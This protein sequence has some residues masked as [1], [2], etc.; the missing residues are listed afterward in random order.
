MVPWVEPVFIEVVD[1]RRQVKIFV[2]IIIIYTE[3]LLPYNRAYFFQFAEG[4]IYNRLDM[5]CKAID[6]QYVLQGDHIVITGSGC[7]H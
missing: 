1:K 4:S 5:I 3:H 6:A 2:I 7:K